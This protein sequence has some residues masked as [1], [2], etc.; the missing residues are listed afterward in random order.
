MSV[1][2]SPSLLIYAINNTD[3]NVVYGSMTALMCVH[4]TTEGD[5]TFFDNVDVHEQS[6]HGFPITET[7]FL[8]THS[9][10]W[11]GRRDGNL[12]LEIHDA[13]TASSET[14]TFTGPAILTGA[15][16]HVG[17]QISPRSA[18]SNK[19]ETIK[20]YVNGVVVLTDTHEWLG[21]GSSFDDTPDQVIGNST[22][23]AFMTDGAGARIS[24]VRMTTVQLS[25]V[26]V[27]AETNSCNVPVLTF[28]YVPMADASST[29]HANWSYV[30]AVVDAPVGCCGDLGRRRPPIVVL[31]PNG[32]RAPCVPENPVT[33]GGKGASG[34]NPGGVGWVPQNVDYGS[35][36]DH[37]DP[38]EGELLT[39]KEHKGIEVWAELVH[40]VY[41]EQT[42]AQVTYRR[43]MVELADPPDYE[44][45]RK[46]EG[47]LT[48]GDVENALGHEQGGPEA[49]TVDLEFSDTID[50]TLRTL[51]DDQ[52]LEGD[53]VRVKLA[54][55]EGRAL[56]I[57]PRII[58]RAIVQRPKLQSRLRGS[59]SAVDQLFSDFGPFG[60]NSKFPFWT[61]GDLGSAMEGAPS[62]TKAQVI[63]SLFG[64]KS[65]EGAVDPITG[66]P[67]SKG[68]LPSFYCGMFTGITGNT[69]REVWVWANP[70]PFDETIAPV[71]TAGANN[72][73]DG[74]LEGNI[75]VI[76]LAVKDGKV[77]GI[78]NPAGNSYTLGGRAVSIFWSSNGATAADSYIIFMYEGSW[79]MFDPFA[80][81]ACGDIRVRYKTHDNTTIDGYWTGGQLLADFRVDFE[82]WEDGTDALT[83]Q[84]IP[85]PD[86][87]GFL[88]FGLGPWYRYLNIYGSD[89]G[90]NDAEA[91]HSRVLLDPTN[92]D[93]ILVPG[94]NFDQHYVL[95]TND[96]GRDFYITGIWVRGPLLEDHI[97][98][99]VNITANAIGRT[100]DGEGEEFPI[101]D[102]YDVLQ[103]WLENDV[104]NKWSAGPVVD[105]VD[106]PIWEDGT[107]KIRTSSFR[108]RQAFT[109]EQ[110]GGRGLTVAW[111]MDKPRSVTD[112]VS[113]WMRQTDSRIGINRHGQIVVWGLDETVDPATWPRIDEVPQLYGSITRVSGEDRANVVS[114]PWD[115]DPDKD[116][117][118]AGPATYISESA[119]T[120]FKNRRKPGAPIEFTMFNDETQVRWVLRRTLARLKLGTA[121]VEVSG[122]AGF[123]D[124]DVGDGVILTS[125]DGIGSAGYV[126]HPFII[127]RRRF[128]V[129][130]RLT[131]Y[132]LWDVRDVIFAT[133]FETEEGAMDG[134]SALFYATDNTAIAPSATNDTDLAPIA[135]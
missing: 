131:T 92:R 66:E 22:D 13:R 37:P 120:K 70:L 51:L 20:L 19:T 127:L 7:A 113:D 132:T 130:S 57:R 46:Q 41:P 18:P 112:L 12:V 133:L 84:T 96:D 2:F 88:A 32:P 97:N 29:G 108:T 16:Y 78:S 58:A 87:W 73:L 77:S 24:E 49:G 74:T 75:T 44:G 85:D 45:G 55:D 3:L 107:A 5:K 11:F 90:A 14:K 93:D 6:T 111:Y 106:Y 35:V 62:D 135:F 53:E 86:E 72:R 67:S 114:G 80:V 102:A 9:Y 128:S 33:N 30:G 104:I 48:V 54:S 50:R 17:F 124:H 126:D 36:P 116:Q 115:W 117:W 27:L 99:I 63:P 98:G 91:T 82:S 68:L 8:H 15:D 125:E 122:S 1:L 34:C 100:E 94:I 38:P 81:P 47:L 71:W 26:Q 118:R 40:T 110:L 121:L 21:N 64:E 61:F 42:P 60:P 103:F 43:A 52:E 69:N 23:A 10:V 101:I 4:C 83:L 109:A 31:P 134:L 105:T 79:G 95:F 59:L 25:D 129:R 56:Q 76:V 89:L 119:I 123:L 39:N 65:D 28:K